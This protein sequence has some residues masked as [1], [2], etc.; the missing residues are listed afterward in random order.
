MAAINMARAHA[1]LAD[2]EFTTPDD[3]RAVIAPVLAHR[4]TEEGVSDGS[5]DINEIVSD[6]IRQ[7]PIERTNQTMPENT[8]T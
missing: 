8:T 5:L 2:R 6:L 4:V 1:V 7:V 3:V